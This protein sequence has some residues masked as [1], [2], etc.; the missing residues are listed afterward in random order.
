M[1]A[2][3][4]SPRE[5]DEHACIDRVRACLARADAHPDDIGLAWP[6][7]RDA[8]ALADARAW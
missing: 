7:R 1:N 6:A 4:C 2:T 8:A 5:M 3:A